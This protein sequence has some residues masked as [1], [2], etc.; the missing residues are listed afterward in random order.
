MPPVLTEHV[1]E[2][3]TGRVGDLRLQTELGRARHEDQHLHDPD[4]VQAANRIRGDSERVERGMTR[5]LTT[6]L[7]VDVPTHDALAQEL[8]VLEGQLT[9]HVDTGVNRP[10]VLVLRALTDGGQVQAESLE[11]LRSRTALGVN[12][13]HL[14]SGL[15]VQLP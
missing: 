7:E 11:P 1:D 12:L 6:G 10:V 8:A 5:Q 4:L 9:R 3:L 2:Q 13:S 15:L 14:F